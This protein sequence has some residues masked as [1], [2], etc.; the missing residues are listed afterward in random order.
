MRSQTISLFFLVPMQ[1]NHV[2]RGLFP[3]LDSFFR[4][5]EIFWPYGVVDLAREFGI[6]ARRVNRL[7]RR[8][9]NRGQEIT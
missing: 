6:S 5:D 7:I 4:L 2:I 3:D 9:L 8:Y 1:N